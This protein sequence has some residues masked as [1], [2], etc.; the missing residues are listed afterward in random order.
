M[1]SLLPFL[2]L[3]NGIGGDL[4]IGWGSPS[5]KQSVEIIFIGLVEFLPESGTLV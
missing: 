5:L 3:I 1:G 2:Y 4:R